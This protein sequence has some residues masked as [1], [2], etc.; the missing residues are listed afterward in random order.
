MP[1]RETGLPVEGA[2]RDQAQPEIECPEEDFQDEALEDFFP[3]SDPA[4][5]HRFD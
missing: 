4:A 5:S 2:A 3:A 1:T